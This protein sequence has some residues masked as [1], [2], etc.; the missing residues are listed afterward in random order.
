MLQEFSLALQHEPEGSVQNSPPSCAC[1][2]ALRHSWHHSSVRDTT[3]EASAHFRHGNTSLA[4]W[5][6]CDAELSLL[7]GH[8]GWEC[9]G[10]AILTGFRSTKCS[11][12]NMAM[13]KV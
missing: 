4:L 7:V 12:P 10:S 6:V 9:V 1:W 11:K 5:V 2:P 3:T 8:A 13:A